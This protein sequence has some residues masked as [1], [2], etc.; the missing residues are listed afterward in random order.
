MPATKL[1]HH[2]LIQRPRAYAELLRWLRRGTVEKRIFLRSIRRGH[3]VCDIGANRGAFTSLFSDLVGSD[4]EVHAFEPGPTTF[5]MLEAATRGRSNCQLN[6]FAL[7]AAIGE[8]ILLQPG[9]DDGQ[10]SLQRHHEGSWNDAEIVHEHPCRVATLDDYTRQFTRLDFIKID[11]EGAELSVLRGAQATLARLS[12]VLFLEVH[13]AWTAAFDYTPA[14]LCQWLWGA[15]YTDFV[16]AGEQIAPFTPDQ[17]ITGP[18][19]L[20]CA[21]PGA[22][23]DVLET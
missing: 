4:G 10:A 19:N 3:V 15:G 21:K 23:P 2:L 1:I 6:Q 8:A 14:D 22:L 12:P 7:G 13:A 17:P 18:T 16:L 5:T 20:L 9:R 11:V